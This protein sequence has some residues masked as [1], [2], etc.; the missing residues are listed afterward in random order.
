MK[1]W[2]KLLGNIR[3][4]GPDDI[5]DDVAEV[6]QYIEDL[7]LVVRHCATAP[8]KIFRGNVKVY[9]P[10]YLHQVANQALQKEEDEV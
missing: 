8:T 7:E 6:W 10:N 5:A 9:I 2:Q 1:R 4:L 3:F